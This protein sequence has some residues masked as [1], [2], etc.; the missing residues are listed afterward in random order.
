M[1]AKVPNMYT[2]K[3]KLERL[4]L[5]ALIVTYMAFKSCQK[6][7]KSSERNPNGRNMAAKVS[8]IDSKMSARQCQERT[9]TICI[10]LKGFSSADF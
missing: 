9:E 1:A 8:K 6:V 4:N 2:E 5:G 10:N 7:T 3:C